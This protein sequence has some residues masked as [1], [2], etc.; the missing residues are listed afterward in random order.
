MGFFNQSIETMAREQL[1]AY[2]LEKLQHMLA[3]I[4]GR[5][6][7]YTTKLTGANATPQDFRS[8]DDL[9]RLPFTTKSELVQA[10]ADDPPFGTNAT[11][12]E[13]AYTR[14]HQTSGTTGTPLRVVDTAESWEWWG[15]CWGYVLAGAGVTANDRLFLPFSFGPF[16][17]FWAA[18]LG[19]KRIGA[20]LISGGGHSS[21]QRLQIMRDLQV[22]VMC[23]TPTYAL[24][25]A[26]T[27][28]EESLDLRDI[29]LRLTIHA[30]EPGANVPATKARIQQ[31]WNAKC[32]D[33]AGASE[34]GAHSFECE[35][36]PDGIHVIESEFIVEVID[37]QTDEALA[38]G[39]IG[40]LVITN[41]G[42]IGFPV[43]RYRTGDMVKFVTEPCSCGRTF[44]RFEGGIIGRADDMVVVRGVNIFPAA[45]ENLVRQFTAIDEF[46]TQITN[47]RE[48]AEL[49]I[50]IECKDGVDGDGTCQAVAQT[51]QNVLGLRPF[52]SAVPRHT[53]PR[54]ELKAKRFYLLSE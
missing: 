41:L 7:F 9:A 49:Q 52:V 24:R 10:Q 35:C 2:Q 5:N 3:Q 17:G 36:Q 1:Q 11:F 15:D 31:A 14:Y 44:G 25:L 50:E 48:M 6:R 42:R 4:V 30:G 43:V 13:S 38:P 23:C 40:E 53:L 12:P 18:V 29:P 54:F 46:R 22:T 39:E 21:A 51:V 32:F 8:L 33:H 37:P 20:L 19:A 45:I 47:R 27:A 16:I 34:V 28:R 26:E